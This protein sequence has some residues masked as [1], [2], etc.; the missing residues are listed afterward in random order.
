M[1]PQVLDSQ[2]TRRGAAITAVTVLVGLL[3]LLLLLLLPYCCSFS[4]ATLPL[5]HS[6]RALSLLFMP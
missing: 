5:Q 1:Q 2:A 6:A 3:L 4:T